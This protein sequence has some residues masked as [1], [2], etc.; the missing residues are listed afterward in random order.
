VDAVERLSYDDALA[1][2]LSASEHVQRYRW[3]ARACRGLTVLDL[4]CGVGYGTQMLREEATAAVG[5][6]RDEGALAEATAAAARAGSDAV[7][8]VGDAHRWLDQDL[9]GRFDA[10]VCFEG[11]EHLPDLEHALDRLAVHARRGVRLLLSVPNSRTFE[12]RNE[13]HLTDLDYDSAMTVFSGF[14]D[15]RVYFQYVAEGAVILADGDDAGETARL[16]LPDRSEPEYANTFLCAVNVPPEDLDAAAAHMRFTLAPY[17]SR[18]LRNLA[19]ANE[20]LWITNR[21]LG[22]QLRDVAATLEEGG[23]PLAALR[24]GDTAV[25]ALVN[26]LVTSHAAQVADYE[27]RL[28]ALEAHAVTGWDYFHQLRGRKFVRLVLG[29]MRALGR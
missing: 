24:S 17:Q 16:L 12:E 3:A 22:R 8:E 29:A 26:K 27:R 23:G 21:E 15:G 10:I 2:S 5:V 13:F 11:L 6:D 4:C 25:G 20:E 18:E 19:K 9:T 28:A 14:P 7:F 1:K